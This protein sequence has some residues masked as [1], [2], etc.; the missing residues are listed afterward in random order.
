MQDFFRAVNHF[1]LDTPALWQIDFSWEG[2]SWISNDD[3][4][5]SVISFRRIDK[6]GNEIITVCNFLPVLREEYKIGVP[7]D[8]IYSELF[9]SDDQKFGG[10]GIT[11]GDS[12]HTQPQSMH[13]YEQSVRLTLPPMSVIFLTCKRRKTKKLKKAIQ[14]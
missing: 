8:G 6:A 9:S 10:N 12:I 14:S 1:Y 3:Y 5:Q 7:F 2:F 13:G 11:N 4:N